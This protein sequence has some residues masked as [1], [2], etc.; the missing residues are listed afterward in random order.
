MI[1]EVVAKQEEL[2][3]PKFLDIQ[4]DKDNKDLKEGDLFRQR[5]EEVKVFYEQALKYS[6]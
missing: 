3:H 2:K 4:Y 6:K 1:A 5:V